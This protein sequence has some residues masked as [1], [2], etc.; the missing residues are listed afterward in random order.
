MEV[1]NMDNNT[2]NLGGTTMYVITMKRNPAGYTLMNTEAFKE[3][4]NVYLCA[5]EQGSSYFGTFNGCTKFNTFL[6]AKEWYE[7]NCKRIEA[8]YFM[9]EYFDISTLNIWEIA[10]IPKYPLPAP[11]DI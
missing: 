2:K 10:M 8:Y 11:Y 3:V 1:D 5:L 7:K 9:R 6:E 4:E